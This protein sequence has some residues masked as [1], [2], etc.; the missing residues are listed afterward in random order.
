MELKVFISK[1]YTCEKILKTKPL[2]VSPEDHL[3][4]IRYMHIVDEKAL[5]EARNYVEEARGLFRK[6]LKI[7][8]EIKVQWVIQRENDNLIAIYSYVL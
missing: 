5:G 8:D 4:G 6:E 7:K 1:L 3:R 2:S